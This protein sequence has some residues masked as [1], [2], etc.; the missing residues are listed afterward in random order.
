M[1]LEVASKV[2]PNYLRYVCFCAIVECGTEHIEGCEMIQ[3]LYKPENVSRSGQM[4]LLEV[5]KW[6]TK[7]GRV[8]V[9]IGNCLAEKPDF[10]KER[11]R[12]K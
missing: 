1:A 10:L 9:V 6:R 5:V 3:L 4:E 11:V 8:G 12:G 7:G 2:W